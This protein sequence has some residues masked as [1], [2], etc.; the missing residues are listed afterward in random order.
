[1]TGV[2]TISGN[3]HWVVPVMPSLSWIIISLQSFV[4]RSERLDFRRVQLTCCER[5]KPL[6]FCRPPTFRYKLHPSSFNLFLFAKNCPFYTWWFIPLSK[7]VIT[8][9]IPFIARVITHLLS[10]IWAAKYL[11]TFLILHIFL[12][13]SQPPSQ[14]IWLMIKVFFNTATKSIELH[15]FSWR[16]SFAPWS[17]VVFRGKTII[18]WGSSMIVHDFFY[19]LPWISHVFPC[20]LHDVPLMRPPRCHPSGAVR[21]GRLA[22]RRHRR[23][24]RHG[25]A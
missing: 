16:S 15:Q 18:L 12:G 14:F 20:F 2:T 10:G 6:D 23:H 21:H 8:L 19:D 3:L 4:E 22:R 1:M 24:V 7:W 25:R 13:W 5:S 17:Y 9:I 11:L